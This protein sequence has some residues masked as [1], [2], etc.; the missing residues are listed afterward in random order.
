MFF[1]N[2]YD[3]SELATFQKWNTICRWT[4]DKLFRPLYHNYFL[5]LLQ[6]NEVS[7]STLEKQL[8]VINDKI[9][10]FEVK[11]RIFKTYC[12]HYYKP[13]NFKILENLCSR[14]G[15]ILTNVTFEYGIIRCVNI[16]KICL[17]SELIFSKWPIMSYKILHG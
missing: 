2:H 9:Q 6:V 4:N 1:K 3:K 15:L 17:T 13:N 11:R 5:H 14:T 8:T 7:L 12:I 16:W 10:A